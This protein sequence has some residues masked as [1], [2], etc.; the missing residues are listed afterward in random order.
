MKIHCIGSNSKG[1][2]YLLEASTG[3]KLLL[4]TGVSYKSIEAASGYKPA[5]IEACII[6]HEHGDHAVYAQE[7]CNKGI[8]LYAT[9]ATAAKLNI[10]C[11]F[12]IMHKYT[13]IKTGGFSFYAFDVIHDAV[14][15]VNFIV[16]HEEMGMFAYITDTNHININAEI[17][18]WLIECN[19]VNLDEP[20][21]YLAKRIRENHSSLQ[22]TLD[23]LSVSGGYKAKSITL[24]HLSENNGSP[25]HM[26][27]TV[28]KVIGVEPCT[29]ENGK[30]IILPET[31]I[32]K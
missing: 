6:T 13:W 1:N 16:Y 12:K 22:N 27:R 23:I 31:P 14:E 2:G 24:C 25:K 4:D 17:N 19:Y 26:I 29:A 11:G 7:V 20:D 21:T 9:I 32:Y 15:P 8:P 18:H 28:H 10:L 5:S 30:V 3:E